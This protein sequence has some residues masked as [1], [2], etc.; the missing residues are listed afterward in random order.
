VARVARVAAAVLPAAVTT[1]FP[2]WGEDLLAAAVIE[3]KGLH[4]AHPRAGC[5]FEALVRC[6]MR[7]PVSLSRLRFTPPPRTSSAPEERN[8]PAFT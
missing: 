5:D 6:M 1:L 2:G 8:A 4:P 3:E 7:S